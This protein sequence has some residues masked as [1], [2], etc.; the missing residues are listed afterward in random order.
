MAENSQSDSGDAHG[1]RGRASDGAHDVSR[2]AQESTESDFERVALQCL[3][4]VARFARSLTRDAADADDLVQ[5]TYL[6]ACEAW[7][8]FQEGSDCRRWLF[9]IC[10]NSFLRA[11]QRAQRMVSIEDQPDAET[12]A[13]VRAHKQARDAGL[14]D[15][16]TRIDVGPALER[17]LDA[18]PD[19]YRTTV[20]MI[21]VEGFSYEEAASTL[22]VPVGTIRSRL[23]R[24][25]RLLQESLIAHARDAGF[26]VNVGT[27]STR[28]SG[29]RS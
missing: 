9:T 7:H 19:V 18:L 8:T 11:R 12:F 24:G 4:D 16:F 17:A 13:A 21:D 28:S 23:F 25:R 29:M 20:R 15:L 5:E 14:D 6:R 26:T 27:D 2:T 1:T 22:D 10:R 3:P